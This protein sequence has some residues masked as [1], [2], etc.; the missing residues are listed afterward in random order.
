[1]SQARSIQ[2]WDQPRLAQA[3]LGDQPL[4]AAAPSARRSR[5]ADIIID[6]F[7][8]LLLPVKAD[9]PVDQPYCSSGALLMLADLPGARLPHANKQ[10]VSWIGDTGPDNLPIRD[11]GSLRCS[12]EPT[13]ADAILDRIIHNAHR[14]QLSGESLRKQKVAKIAAA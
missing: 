9:C 6:D 5:L 8:P 3:D 10:G 2:A 11:S 7:D 12:V 13:L 14:L 1:V 4:K